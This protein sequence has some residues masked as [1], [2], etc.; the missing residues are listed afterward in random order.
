MLCNVWYGMLWYGMVFDFIPYSTLEQ[1]KDFSVPL[2]SINE[3]HDIAEG[4]FGRI[5]LAEVDLPDTIQVMILYYTILYNTILYFALC[6]ASLILTY[7]LTST[8][9]DSNRFA[10]K[11]LK[12]EVITEDAEI[13]VEEAVRTKGIHH[14]NVVKLFAVG[15]DCL[16]YFIVL[17]HMVN[18]DLKSYLRLC[19]ATSPKASPKLSFDHLLRLVRDVN[20]GFAYLTEM[21]FVH[22]D[23]A[24]RNVMLDE[25]FTAKI[26]DFGMARNLYCT[27]VWYGFYMCAALAFVDLRCFALIFSNGLYSFSSITR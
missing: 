7:S 23:L 11:Y 4:Q 2:E 26:G 5:V 15:F 3:L 14:N 18:G 12:D 16:P 8:Q 6:C 9:H 21:N 13:F 1:L 24:S 17:E 20:A 25:K 27:K 22:R 19:A 10:V